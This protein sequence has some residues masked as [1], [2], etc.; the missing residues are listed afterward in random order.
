[1]A[2]LGA[3]LKNEIGRLSRRELRGQME[4]LKKTAAAQRKEIAALKQQVAALQKQLVRTTGRK[5][6]LQAPALLADGDGNEVRSLRFM[7]KGMAPLR[8][9]LGVSQAA[10]AKLVGVSSQTIYNWENGKV[11]P[12]AEQLAALAAVRD[13]GKREVQRRLS[14]LASA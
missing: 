8:K 11:K 10:L 12:R 9:R 4:P 6:S 13:L 2:N 5:A 7:A 3:L 14:S 1:M